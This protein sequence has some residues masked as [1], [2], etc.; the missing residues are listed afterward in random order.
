MVRDAALESAERGDPDWAQRVSDWI[1]DLAPG[2]RFTADDIRSRF[3]SSKASGSVI[4]S[5]AKRR[6][7][8]KTGY[9]ESKALSR[10]GGTIA[11]WVRT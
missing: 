5:A 4:R 6:V 3:G 7:I 9:V 10:H 1:Y 8:L 2:A 11:E